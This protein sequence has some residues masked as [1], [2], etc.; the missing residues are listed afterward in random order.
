MTINN[1]RFPFQPFGFAGLLCLLFTLFVTPNTYSQLQLKRLGHAEE[2]GSRT[3]SGARTKATPPLNLPFFDDFSKPYTNPNL[4]EVYADTGRWENSYTVWV[5]D[6][7]GINPPTINVATFDGLDSIGDPYNATEIFLNGFTDSLVSRPIDLSENANSNPVTIAERNAVYLSFYYQ[8]KGNGE[9]PD[10]DDYFQVQFRNASNEWETVLTIQPQSTFEQD[11]FYQS[12][13]KVDGDRFFTDHFQFRFRTF[14]RQSGPYDTWNI[15]YVYLN[16]NRSASD[17]S[18]PDQAITSPPSSIFPNQYRAIPY[19]HFL[20]D[21]TVIAPEFNVFNLRLGDPEVLNYYLDGTF[22]SYFY[23]A[24]DT[25]SATVSL[26]TASERINDNGGAIFPFESQPVTVKHISLIDTVTALDP[27][28]DAA[29]IELSTILVTGDNINPQDGLPADDYDPK[30]IPI[31]FR[32]N[33]TVRVQYDLSNYYAYDDG[34]AEYAGGLISAGNVFAYQFDLPE[35]L[36]DTLRVLEAFDIYFPPFGLTSNQNVDF[37][38]FD[39]ENGKPNKILVRISSVAIRKSGNNTF[40]RIRFLP[41]VQIEQRSFFIG[42][43]QPVAGQLL[44]GIDNS[45]DTGGKMFFNTEGS[46]NPDP[47]RWEANTLIKGSF[48]VRPVF[49]TGVVDPTTGTEEDTRLA[50]YPNPNRGAFE[51]SGKPEN[52][53]VMTMTGQPVAFESDAFDDRTYV[54]VNAPSG[55]YIVRYRNLG[56]LH[57]QKIIITE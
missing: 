52:I 38:V 29:K 12:M 28:A 21:P 18:F 7:L 45:N 2:S 6:G 14:G 32:S 15:D 27:R 30:Y 17:V 49:G 16:K 54:R 4:K 48:M 39:M 20:S 36:H 44:V 55:L 23:S 33:D 25:T 31:D 43:R 41:A 46:I 26:A 34:V 24:S 56:A 51:I 57:A 9:A 40:Q 5:N 3:S 35:S 8:W 22:T 1:S 37:F 47:S 13:V 19:Y 10:P 42:W 11:K 50:L 53:S